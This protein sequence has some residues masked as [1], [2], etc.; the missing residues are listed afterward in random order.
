MPGMTAPD[1]T[2]SPERR[3]LLESLTVHR[4]FLLQTV[5]GL[6]DEQAAARPTASALSLGGIVKHVAITE[7]SW[8]RFVVEG[9]AG[10][11][12]WPPPPEVM[13]AWGDQFTML[14]G[15]T[16]AALVAGYAEVA[17]A[18]DELVRTVDLDAAHPLPPAPWFPPGA[19]RSARRVF[20]HLVG[21]IAQHSG[22][23]D[24]LRES[25]DG[26]RTMG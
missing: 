9:P 19:T 17:A 6:T 12:T 10:F 25:I 5:Q 1:T 7:A 2:L 21:E 22:H 16:L 8:A 3:D 14:P 20:V 26:A 23:A 24:I 18:T 4:G 15:E 11:G 13:A